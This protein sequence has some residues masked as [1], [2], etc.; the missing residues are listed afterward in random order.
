M[1]MMSVFKATLPSVNYIFRNGKPGIFVQGKYMTDVPAEI[2]ELTEEIAAGHPHIYIDAAEA[3]VDSKFVDPIAALTEKIR[4]QLVEEMAAATNPAN[5]MGTSVPEVLKPANSSD[6]AEASAGAQG[7][8]V[9]LAA[10]LM[11]VA[12]K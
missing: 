7:S 3:E 12:K 2:S 1:S 11:N 6:I 10:R 8:G 4:K 9:G 5:D